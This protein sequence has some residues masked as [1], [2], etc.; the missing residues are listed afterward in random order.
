M[1]LR[2]HPLTSVS[3]HLLHFYLQWREVLYLISLECLM[4][5]IGTFIS[6][7]YPT[8]EQNLIGDLNDMDVS[9]AVRSGFRDK[10]HCPPPTPPN[11]P[12]PSPD[13]ISHS[14]SVE[15]LMETTLH[16]VTSNNKFDIPVQNS[17]LWNV[18]ASVAHLFTKK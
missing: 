13:S 8:Q 16:N 11:P 7:K 1:N 3:Y 12:P 2:P 6:I 17:S 14:A 9:T 18:G 4:P 5:I 10:P 15:P